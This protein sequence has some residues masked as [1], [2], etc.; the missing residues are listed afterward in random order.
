MVEH[1][2]ISA[3][4]GSVRSVGALFSH[5]YLHQCGTD[6]LIDPRFPTGLVRYLGG[7]ALLVSS[8]SIVRNLRD[9]DN[10]GAT[11][12]ASRT[13]RAFA[14]SAAPHISPS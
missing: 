11:E 2:L 12:A 8:E 4:G 1:V 9:K 14:S 3:P 6:Q 10:S 5:D 7:F 13:A